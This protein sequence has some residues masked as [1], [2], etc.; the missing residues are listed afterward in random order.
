[1][2]AD[3]NTAAL[4][5][6]DAQLAGY[7]REVESFQANRTRTAR[8]WGRVGWAVAGVSLAAN[9]ALGIALD[10]LLPLEKL[11]PA[12]I[13]VHADGTTTTTMNFASLPAGERQAAIRAALWH[14]VR[15]RES[16]DFAAA[17]YRYD[18]TSLMSDP[19]VQQGYQS[20]FLAKGQGSQSPQVTIGRK[21]QISVAL[22][23]LSLVR[24]NVAL[25]RFRR[26]VTLYGAAPETTTWTATV[27]FRTEATLPE[28]ARLADPA[29][30]IV[31]NYQA[32]KDTP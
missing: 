14:Y 25:V 4:P 23:S 32:M 10:S 27:G 22:V 17:Q 28:S 29:G 6:D 3:A 31:T 18:V 19:E 7:F 5:V 9:L 16:Y 21:G 30:L 20:W 15:D 24:P 2:N 12:F 1:M 8:R 11:V 13:T 26:T